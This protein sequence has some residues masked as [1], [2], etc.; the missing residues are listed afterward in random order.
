[1]SR[2][3]KAIGG[4][5]GL[6]LT[7][8][9]PAHAQT[10]VAGTG[11][12]SA[13]PAADKPAEQI[14]FAADQL[15][16]Q[17]DTDIVTASGDVRMVREGN[18]VRA[19]RVVWNRKTGQVR[20]IG[21]VR[22]VNPGGDIAYGDSVVL[23]DTLKDGMVEN[24][25]IVLIDGGRIAARRGVQADGISTLENAAYSPCPVTD[26]N[27]CPKN[28]SWKISAVKVIYDP[29]RKR[30][31]FNGARLDVFGIPIAVLPGLV[32]P[33]GSGGGSG[34]LIP[35]IEYNRT[36]GVRI[37]LPYYFR[38]SPNRDL[39]ITPRFYSAVQ[40]TLEGTYRALTDNGAYRIGGF[41]TYSRR[42]VAGT[43]TG[44]NEFRGYLDASGKFQ[45]DPLWSVSASIRRVTDRTL[46]RRYDI[47]YDDKLRS[48]LSLERIDRDSYFALNGWAVQTLQAGVAQG[49]IPVALPEIDYRR[50][51]DDPLLGGR[52]ELQLNSLALARTQ[53]QDT[54]RAFAGARWDLRRLTNLGQE[55]ILTA[56]ARG[57]VYHSKENALTTTVQ[58]RGDSGWQGRAIGALAAEIRWPLVGALWGGTQ[59][60]TPRLQFVASP[61]TANLNIPNEDA[62]SVDLE[63]SNLFA[64][65]RFPGYDRWED[66]ARVTYGLDW[67][68]DAP[69]FSVAATVG[70]SYRLNAKPT[71]FP[72]GTGLNDRLSD[73]VGR[74][75][76][77]YRDVV[78]LTH[79]Y[80]LD[81]D[82][83]ALRRNEVDATIG[84]DRTYAL[85]GYLRLNRNI[86]S[87]LEDLRDRE[88]IRVGGRVQVTRYISV[89]G[90]ATV[91]L[92]DR[93]EDPLSIATG[94][95]PVRHRLGI[96]YTD[97]CLDIGFTWKRDYD[98]SGDAQRGD[99]YLLRLAFR[100]LGR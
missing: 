34:L 48:T 13:A 66:G 75:T 33:T 64:L 78:T 91:D 24:L 14:D 21:N 50:R 55:I 89:F 63:D 28:P 74:T 76:I 19:D 70:Q 31:R 71:L 42:L 10:V 43:L 77:R 81:K 57:D 17:N 11:P 18:R 16:Y 86:S 79:R 5:T 59:R 92:T 56:Y 69:R 95:Q 96:A 49:G 54:Q 98:T 6:W 85:I 93:A 65:N 35:N 38:L 30:I 84:D 9:A 67:N 47:S 25:L 60:L 53:G 22:I 90:S 20:A 3:I 41:V 62:R 23:T 82:G 32:V 68:F 2:T 12:A 29:V 44:S 26:S 58:Y 87:T 80:R 1:V 37:D 7:V 8:A 51:F 88:E 83:F 72:D 94:Y 4:A 36:N 61:T 40:P 97:D 39:T 46:L 73:I 52:V 15:E 100:N 27:G 99:S 45:I